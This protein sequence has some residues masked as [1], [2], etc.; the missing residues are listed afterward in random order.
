MSFDD[1][2]V[3]ACGKD[4]AGKPSPWVAFVASE[5]IRDGGRKWNGLCNC[6]SKTGSV[7]DGC[8]YFGT[9]Q[10]ESAFTVG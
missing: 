4:T 10:G 6:Y 9:Y 1:A 8:D 2:G 3:K 7:G 5:L